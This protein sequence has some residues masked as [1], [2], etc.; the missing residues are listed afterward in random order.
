MDDEYRPS[1][2]VCTFKVKSQDP[3]AHKSVLNQEIVS[4]PSAKYV[5][6]M[7]MRFI[8]RLFGFKWTYDPYVE[9]RENKPIG[10]DTQG[11][12]V[13]MKNGKVSYTPPDLDYDTYFPQ[14][15]AAVDVK[16]GDTLYL[17]RNG[18]LT[19]KSGV[20]EKETIPHICGIPG[21]LEPNNPPCSNCVSIDPLGT[22]LATE[23]LQSNSR[24]G[25]SQF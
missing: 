10:T 7:L 17:D 13:Y 2:W 9:P 24:F 21:C 6:N 22:Y 12:L 19:N 15:Y 8:D 1:D 4:R 25:I 11:K 20:E 5:P 16:E 14:A 3:Y 18:T 23:Q